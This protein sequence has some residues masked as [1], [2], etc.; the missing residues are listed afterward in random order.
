MCQSTWCS[1]LSGM[2]HGMVWAWT[3]DNVRVGGAN[4]GEFPSFAM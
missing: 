1:V 4:T 2:A 3:L